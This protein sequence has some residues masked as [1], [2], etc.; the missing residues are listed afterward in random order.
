MKLKAKQLS[1]LMMI[2]Y[3]VSYF[4]RINYGAVL[5]EMVADTG[6]AKTELSMAITGSFITYGVGQVISGWLGDRISPKHLMAGG[7]AVTA[8]INAVLPFF[9]TPYAM[10]G[11]W[12]VN[13]FA[14]ALMWPPLVR[15]MVAVFNEEEYKHA[16]VTVSYGSSGGTILIYLIAPIMVSLLSWKGIFWLASLLA[17]LIIPVWLYFCPNVAVQRKVPRAETSTAPTGSIRVLFTPL[18]LACMVAIVLQGSLRDG[19]TTWMP[20]YI[21]ETYQLGSAISIL[22]GV[23]LPLFSIL[24]FR[25][26]EYIYVNHIRSP[27]TCAAVVFGVGTLA[28]AVLM[29][30]TGRSAVGSIA[31][32]AVLTGCMHGVNLIL[33][34]ML[35]HYFKS[36]GRVS[37]ISGVLNA[38]TYV[39]SAASTYL[40]PLIMGNGSWTTTVLLWLLTAAAGTVLCAVCIPAWKRRFS[41]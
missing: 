36:T 24:C 11:V 33:I 28:A 8:C 27:L 7:L 38:C 17:V 34:C 20:T 40:I 3:M 30:V 35:P 32:T 39:G 18:M 12:C 6:F 16:S 9:T 4:T 37:L 23:A 22:T 19:V 10:A 15:I 29:L 41:K 13:G 31:C 21:S 1:L 25:V 14:Q 5:V 2:T 26:T